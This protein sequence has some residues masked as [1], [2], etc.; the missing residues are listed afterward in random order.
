MAGSKRRAFSS[1]Q[2]LAAVLAESD[3]NSF[4]EDD[5]DRESDVLSDQNDDNDTAASATQSQDD[6]GDD[7]DAGNDSDSDTVTYDYPGDDSNDSQEPAVWECVDAGYQVPNDI[8]F[9]G[10]HGIM[11]SSGLSADSKPSEIFLSLITPQIIELMSDETN[12]YATQFLEHNQA[13]LKPHSKVRRW[14]QTD[15]AEIRN[16][17]G[18]LLNMG[19]VR[20]PST[21]D[22]WSMDPILATPA[23]SSVMAHDRFEVLL[24]F[25]HFDNNEDAVE[26][27]RLHKIRQLCDAIL[28]R[29]QDVY[30]PSKEL[31]I[32]ES[33]VL[34]RGR[35]VFRQYIPGKKHKYGVKLYLL[36][37]P[38][39]YVWNAMVY[40][41][42][43]DPISGLGHSEAVV[44]KLM[45]KRLDLGHQLY[46]DNFYTGMPLAKELLKRKT[47]LCGT[48]C[49]TRQ[50][51]PAPVVLATLQK[52]AST[53]RRQG[54]IIV[55]KWKDKRD[56]L[57]LSSFHTGALVPSRNVNRRGE[58]INKPDCVLSYNANM[59]GVDRTD[60]LTSYYS[61]L[62]KTVRW[63]KKIALHLIDTAL[64]N[65]YLLYRKLGGTRQQMWFRVQVI[66]DLL[67][68]EERSE[69]PGPSRPFAHHKAS[70]LSRL[71]GQHFV[72]LIPCDEGKPKKMRKCVVCRLQGKRKETRYHCET[73][74]S[75]PALCISPCYKIY[76][77]IEDFRTLQSE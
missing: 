18:I 12:R 48:V 65:S 21:E 53:T 57:M 2:V 29:F 64:S 66:R 51:L 40:C 32:D 58:T 62:R 54:R 13:T 9:T 68:Y 6:D 27:D 63:Y 60:Q 76:H 3:D 71:G 38:S 8:V 70:D 10:S 59:C 77:T 34:W 72:E 36:C 17:M 49:K 43:M 14:S 46:V 74:M 20:K 4:E 26:G 73:C 24:R 67:A 22:Y 42:K 28:S 75:K 56:V 69:V 15:P 47:L 41:G 52:G 25:W 50:G 16:F 37:E 23:I 35:L 11:D 1:L 39:G 19:L 33:M 30:H 55:T 44:M 7:A 45:E 31:S 61:P 5:T